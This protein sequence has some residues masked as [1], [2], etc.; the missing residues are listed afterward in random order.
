VTADK[1]AGVVRV[2]YESGEEEELELIG[3][4]YEWVEDAGVINGSK[5]NA[6]R[7]VRVCPLSAP[8]LSFS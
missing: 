3:A 1:A 7:A 5:K 2:C 8:S 6:K 4:K